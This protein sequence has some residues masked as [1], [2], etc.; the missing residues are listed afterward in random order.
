MF[1]LTRNDSRAKTLDQCADDMAQCGD[2]VALFGRG[3]HEFGICGG[4]FGDNFARFGDNFF[5]LRFLW[6]VGL[7]Q[8]HLKCHSRTAQQFHD[9]FVHGLY[10]MS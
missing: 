3:E 1:G 4:V 9:L 2:A 7:G 5:K 10:A 8:N 6:L